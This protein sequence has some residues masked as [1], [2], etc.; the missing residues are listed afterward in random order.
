LLG[1]LN[2]L[3]TL[4]RLWPTAHR[5][6]PA[7]VGVD[8]DATIPAASLLGA[9][10]LHSL[11]YLGVLALAASFIAAKIRPVWIRALLFLLGTFVLV[12]SNWGGAADFAKQW[13]AEAILLGAVVVGI[14]WIMR[15]NLLGAFLAIAVISLVEGA[16]ELLGQP[17]IFYRA[18]GYIALILLVIVLVSPIWMWRLRQNA[19]EATSGAQA[20]P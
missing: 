14:V 1:L 16:V 6:T 4:S 7:S 8:F 10:L 9:T 13:L 18:N 2:L 11:L 12:G 20:I 19:P 3:Q 15:F 5:G 17:E